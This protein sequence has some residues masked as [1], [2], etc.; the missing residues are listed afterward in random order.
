LVPAGGQRDHPPGYAYDE[1]RASLSGGNMPARLYAKSLSAFLDAIDRFFG[2]AGKADQTLFPRAFGLNT[3]R[4]CG[5]RQP[6]TAAC[7]SH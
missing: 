4:H 5:R 1:L 3:R 2:D 6:L 7:C